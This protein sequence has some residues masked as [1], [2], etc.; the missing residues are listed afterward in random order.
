MKL[1][2]TFFDWLECKIAFRKRRK[3]ALRIRKGE[4]NARS[5][6]KPSSHSFTII[7]LK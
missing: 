1:L 4:K 3:E 7:D 6:V 5:N 2:E